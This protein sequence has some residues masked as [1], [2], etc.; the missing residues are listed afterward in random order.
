MLDRFT[1][2]IEC[3]PGKLAAHAM[4]IACPASLLHDRKPTH[5]MHTTMHT[6]TDAQHAHHYLQTSC[7]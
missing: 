4:M 1:V 7:A 3:L 5:S 2:G 6:T